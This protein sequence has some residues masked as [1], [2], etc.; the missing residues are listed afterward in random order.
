MGL[1]DGSSGMAGDG[2]AAGLEVLAGLGILRE[3]LQ[4]RSF[5]AW[6]Q[7]D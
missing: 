6:P 2:G 5:P 1:R 7:V 3:L 4:K